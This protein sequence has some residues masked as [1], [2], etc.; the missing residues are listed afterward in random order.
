MAFE[1]IIN[2]TETY[3]EIKVS[4]VLRVKLVKVYV[5]FHGGFQRSFEIG[6]FMSL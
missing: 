4:T 2:L 1:L 3:L 6:R 5:Y